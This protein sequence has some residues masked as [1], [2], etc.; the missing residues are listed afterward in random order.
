MKATKGVISVGVLACLGLAGVCSAGSDVMELYRA[1][2]GLKTPSTKHPSAM[3]LVDKYAQAL[4]STASFIEHYE[5]TGEFRAHFPTN[6]PY[7]SYYGG[8]AFRHQ[9]PRRGVTKF[10][11]NKGRYHSEY[12]WDYFNEEEKNI[13]KDKPLIRLW[14]DTRDISYFHQGRPGSV[15]W[16]KD[17]R[18]TIHPCDYL[19]ETARLLGYV[20]SRVRLDQLL[21][22]GDYISVRDRTETVHG[23]ECYVID[24]HTKYGRFIIW[25]DPN[26]GYHAARI[27]KSAK[28]GE[29]FYKPD[30]IIPKGSIYTSYLD[31]LEFK[32]VDNIWVPVDANAGFHRTIGS[33]EYYMATDKRYKRTKIILNPD[34]DK[35]GS[36]A[37]PILEDPNNDPELVNGTIVSY[38]NHQRVEYT[39]RDGRIID[40]KGRALDM[41]K[42]KVF[43]VE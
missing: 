15:N 42:L 27:R 22:Q 11:E 25:L 12:A 6:H 5:E 36:F 17:T 1:E 8:K 35:L 13:P 38:I 10:K 19:L 40:D 39:W 23:S 26:H 34:H 9:V 28:E 21:R 37:D 24:G 7:Y 31:V 33:P 14:I 18:E 3:E 20:E 41:D 30:R 2:K 16:R 4:D 29:S 32:K 43:R